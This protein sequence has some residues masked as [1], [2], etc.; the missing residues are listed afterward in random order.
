MV[1]VVVADGTGGPDV[2][3]LPETVGY[4][5]VGEWDEFGM[6]VE[7]LTGQA[8]EESMVLV[9]SSF[10]SVMDGVGAVAVD[11]AI[12]RDEAAEAEEPDSLMVYLFDLHLA[13]MASEAVVVE[14]QLVV[15]RAACSTTHEMT[16]SSADPRRDGRGERRT[17]LSEER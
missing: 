3:H 12:E 4:V 2:V 15:T 10:V 13:N 1:V 8:V 5:L 17:G 9:Q 14:D 6:V 11:S 16:F 7:E